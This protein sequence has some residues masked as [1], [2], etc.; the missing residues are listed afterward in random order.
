VSSVVKVGHTGYETHENV[1][2]GGTHM[3]EV[4]VEKVVGDGIGIADG[5]GVVVGMGL[6]L[7][8]GIEPQDR[9]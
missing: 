8:L 5:A 9:S 4:L 1:G 6:G 2:A 7:G 3:L